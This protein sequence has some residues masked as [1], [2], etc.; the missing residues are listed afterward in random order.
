MLL[1]AACAVGGTWKEQ[2][3]V[4]F[5]AEAL[6]LDALSAATEPSTITVLLPAPAVPETVAWQAECGTNKAASVPHT[7]CAAEQV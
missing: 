5:E 4:A 2:V 6:V 7:P 1:P 3:K